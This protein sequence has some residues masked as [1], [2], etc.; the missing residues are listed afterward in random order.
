[1]SVFFNRCTFRSPT[2]S[3]HVQNRI[4]VI[5]SAL[6][7]DARLSPRNRF[8][9]KNVLSFDLATLFLFADLDEAAPVHD[10]ISYLVTEYCSE[11]TGLTV[12]FH[13][14]TNEI[15]MTYKD[16]AEPTFF[17]SSTCQVPTGPLGVQTLLQRLGF[18]LLKDTRFSRQNRFM[19]E[20]VLALDLPKLC[21]LAG[22]DQT[23]FYELVNYLVTTYCPELTGLTTMFH[24]TTNEVSVIYQNE[25]A[26]TTDP[27]TEDDYSAPPILSALDLN[28]S[29]SEKIVRV[30]IA[31]PLYTPVPVFFHPV[32]FH[33][34]RTP[35]RLQTCLQ[36]I[37]S[38][39]LNDTRLSPHN[40]LRLKRALRFDFVNLC[41]YEG[42]QETASLYDVLS[43]LVA[44]YCSELIGLTVT[45]SDRTNL[46]DL[47]YVLHSEKS[48][49]M[50]MTFANDFTLPERTEA[51]RVDDPCTPPWELR[52][53]AVAL[54]NSTNLIQMI[55]STTTTSSADHYSDD[56]DVFEHQQRKDASDVSINDSDDTFEHQQRKDASDVGILTNP[57]PTSA[58]RK[59]A[60]DSNILT[61]N[62]LK[63]QENDEFHI[64]DDTTTKMKLMTSESFEEDHMTK[65]DDN[66]TKVNPNNNDTEF[67]N[68]KRNYVSVL[69]DTK[70]SPS[71]LIVALDV[72][73]FN[74]NINVHQNLT[75]HD[76]EKDPST[77][78]HSS[79]DLTMPDTKHETPSVPPSDMPSVSPSNSDTPSHDVTLHDTEYDTTSISPS[80]T[81]T[82]SPSDMPSVSP[83]DTPSVSPSSEASLYNYWENDSGDRYYSDVQDVYL[84]EYP[85]E[86]DYDDDDDENHY[87][88]GSSV[89]I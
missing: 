24:A 69:H 70:M 66:H 58:Q 71:S 80:D 47:T 3:R 19:L 18:A 89:E 85:S 17:R 61:L 36:E 37:G 15:S 68:P 46:L 34:P 40:S 65:N 13:D 11:I 28:P 52:D 75:K 74:V 10:I 86:S 62:R 79:H 64:Y 39:L 20:S 87:Y 14:A 67:N 55:L 81:P 84:D 82:V 9:L 25:L 88:S 1:M 4:Q 5:G 59:D 76:T 44:E 48:N 49:F 53:N 29:T 42:L 8:R 27:E 50:E 31:D 78:H 21:E 12:I 63:H 45:H 77:I 7:E 73:T 60:S 2:G 16:E 33:N 35:L 51:E 54:G 23:A 43:H 32:T 72:S 41:L 30:T 6:L 38:N 56:D 26:P 83:R 22:F 57:S